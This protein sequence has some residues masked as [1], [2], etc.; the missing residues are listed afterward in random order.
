M[1]QISRDKFDRFPRATTE[2]TLCAFDRYGLHGPLPARPALT[3]Q[4]RFLYIGSHICSTL[5]S[6]AAS[7]RR[8][9]A[10]LSLHL[11]QVVRRTFTSK[12]SNMLG[13]QSKAA[14][15]RRSCVIAWRCYFRRSS[16]LRIG[17]NK[18]SALV[19]NRSRLEG[20]GAALTGQTNLTKESCTRRI[21]R[22]IRSEWFK[23]WPRWSGRI[24]S[25]GDPTCRQG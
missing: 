22:T 7:R 23:L 16:F 18:P 17:P 3:P 21:R 10:S 14:R 15:R 5:P 20:S 25:V 24:H 19:P 1:Q 2:F 8:R 9:C 13:A 11:Y 4:I 6:D 12:L